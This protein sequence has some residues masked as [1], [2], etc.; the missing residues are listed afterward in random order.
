MTILTGSSVPTSGHSM[1]GVGKSHSPGVAAQCQQRHE[2]VCA[3]IHKM[4]GG[5]GLG[6]PHLMSAWCKA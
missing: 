5:A 1:Q 3:G 6:G 2:E 4:E